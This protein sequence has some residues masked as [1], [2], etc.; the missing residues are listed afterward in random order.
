MNGDRDEEGA[1]GLALTRE[2][3]GKF[4]KAC[5]SR[6]LPCQEVSF[7]PL[8]PPSLPLPFLSLSQL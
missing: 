8:F 3:K 6:F 5:K 2:H 7:L 1:N 4:G